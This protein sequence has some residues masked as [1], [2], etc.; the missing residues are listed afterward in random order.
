MRIEFA[1]DTVYET[2]GPGQGPRFAKGDIVDF[3]DNIGERWVRRGHKA[4]APKPSF[5]RVPAPEPAAAPVKPA[6]KPL[7]APAT[8]ATAPA[9]VEPKA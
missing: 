2:Q 6:A 1:F 7:P 5:V 9:K 8:P 3:P 4:I